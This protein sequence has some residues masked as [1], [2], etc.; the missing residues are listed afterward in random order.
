MKP[1]LK[2]SRVWIYALLVIFFTPI[3]LSD[4]SGQ[5]ITGSNQIS[6]ENIYN[7]RIKQ[8]N[9]FVDRFNYKTDFNG[10]PIDSAFKKKMPR[11]KLINSL[12]D[13]KDTRTIQNSPDFKSTFVDL[14]SAFVKKV[15]SGNLQIDK[16]SPGIIAEARSRVIY[17]GKPYTIKIFL[18]QERVGKSSIKWVI[19]DV[20]GDVLNFLKSDTAFVRFIPPSSNETDFINLKRALEDTEYLQYYGAADYIPDQM[21]VFFYL[22]NS[23]QM[24]YEYVEE[25]Y[26]H[27]LDIPGW[28]IKVKDFNREEL[29]SGWLIYDL[30]SNNLNQKDYIKSLK[31]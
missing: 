31:N 9:E 21:T 1:Q 2:P 16:L 8:F 15:I 5:G 22:V 18:N 10:N 4:I 24:K 13:L 23:K 25:V 11:E 14:K 28:C 26:Y 30:S 19:A 20:S 27:I 12:F 7:A 3:L 29:N 17:N 6:K